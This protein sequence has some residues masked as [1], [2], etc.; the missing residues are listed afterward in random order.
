MEFVSSYKPHNALFGIANVET[1]D[2]NCRLTIGYYLGES[3]LTLILPQSCQ[4]CQRILVCTREFGEQII[5]KY[6]E[7]HKGAEIY[8]L[9]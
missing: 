1:S 3:A 7:R 5:Q 6:N 2:G 8:F 4:T 9:M